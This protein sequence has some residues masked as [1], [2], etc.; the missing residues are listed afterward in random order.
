MA[1]S[2]VPLSYFVRAGDRKNIQGL[3]G[4]VIADLAPS[5]LPVTGKSSIKTE[6]P[7]S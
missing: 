6:C 7:K 3:A 1:N 2:I 4:P 5:R